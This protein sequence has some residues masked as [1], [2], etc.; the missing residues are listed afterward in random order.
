MTEA[1]MRELVAVHNAILDAC[2]AAH[3]KPLP[4]TE[5]QILDFLK[6]L[7]VVASAPN[8]YLELRQGDNELVVSKCCERI[9]TAHPELFVSDPSR[10]AI[11]SKEDFHG[12]TLEV[13]QAKSQWIAKHGLA[14][15]EALPNTRALAERRAVIPSPLMSRADYV[16][17]DV[18]SK[19]RLAATIGVNGIRRILARTK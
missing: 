9:R 13:T 3:L 6:S 16:A 19:A 5:P 17:L 10:D 15:W 18:H 12:S 14:A 1:E 2:H 4:D 8:G 11:I 7:G